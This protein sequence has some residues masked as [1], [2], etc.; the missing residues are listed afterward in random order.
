MMTYRVPYPARIAPRPDEVR[1]FIDEYETAR[2]FIFT[3]AER[4]T[5]AAVAAYMIAWTAR[6]EHSAAPDETDYPVGKYREA[7]ALYG[8]AYLRP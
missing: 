5:M 7:L 2:G 8:D 4:A 6:L 1:A 3:A